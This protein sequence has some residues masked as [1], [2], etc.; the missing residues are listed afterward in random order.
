M[1]S[2]QTPDWAYLWNRCH[3][4]TAQWGLP[5]GS[6][7]HGESPPF[8]LPNT[9]ELFPLPDRQILAVGRTSP[10]F[11]PWSGAA[12]PFTFGGKPMLD[13]HGEPCW[14]ELVILRTLAATGTG[15]PV[16]LP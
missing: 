6:T 5:L 12:P 9:T 13:C 15:G 10:T 8:L 14:A 7:N 16:G 1:E 4:A 11:S 2:T 3:F